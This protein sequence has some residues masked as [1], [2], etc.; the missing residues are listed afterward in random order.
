MQRMLRRGGPVLLLWLVSGCCTLL[1][2]DVRSYVGGGLPIV[3]NDGNT[4]IGLSL[5]YGCDCTRV[6]GLYTGFMVDRYFPD[7]ASE[8]RFAVEGRYALRSVTGPLRPYV[9]GSVG[10]HRWSY[11]SQ[12]SPGFDGSDNS[13]GAGGGLGVAYKGMENLFPYAEV[14]HR[15]HDGSGANVVQMGFR[16]F[17]NF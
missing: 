17:L 4:D 14:S 3:T 6:P 15:R 2:T 5:D 16:T 1:G 7:N 9:R 12:G 13:L 8:W 11:D 10:L